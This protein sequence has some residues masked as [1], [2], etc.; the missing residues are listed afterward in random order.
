VQEVAVGRGVLFAVN[1]GSGVFFFM[2]SAATWKSIGDNLSNLILSITICD[3]FVFVGTQ[4]GLFRRPFS[5]I[6]PVTNSL[7]VYASYEMPVTFYSFTWDMVSGAAS[8]ELYANDVPFVNVQDNRSASHIN[9]HTLLDLINS[10][11]G[12][13]VNVSDT[14]QFYMVA[15]SATN[16]IVKISNVVHFKYDFLI[17]T[18]SPGVGNKNPQVHI[19]GSSINFQLPNGEAQLSLYSLD[20][21]RVSTEKDI[22]AGN[23]FIS[24][25]SQGVYVVKLNGSRKNGN[26]SILPISSLL[27]LEH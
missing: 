4:R 20:G 15:R 21:V 3:D 23:L 25:L 11:T 17:Q 8:Y 13:S 26:C 14:V 6:I 9:A 19:P 12:G 10:K 27:T 18:R 2:D 5:D 7:K 1:S 24:P 22:R 16:Q